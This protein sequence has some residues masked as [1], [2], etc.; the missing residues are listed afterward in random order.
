MVCPS[1]SMEVGSRMQ[2][3]PLCGGTA[4]GI[5]IEKSPSPRM[6]ADTTKGVMPM[7]KKL[8]R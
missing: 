2:E 5:A 4:G 6:I 3:L 7:V 8:L 1:S